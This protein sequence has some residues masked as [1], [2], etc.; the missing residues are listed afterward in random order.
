MDRRPLSSPLHHRTEEAVHA[1][2]LG[3]RV[4]G[5]LRQVQAEALA[6]EAHLLCILLGCCVRAAVRELSG[7]RPREPEAME[8][9][10]QAT[11]QL[12]V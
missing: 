5:R 11:M 6:E 10:K 3:Q 12:Q 7:Q 9:C 8:A 4:Q 2:A 1:A